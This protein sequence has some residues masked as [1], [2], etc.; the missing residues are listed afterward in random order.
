ME[1]I[2]KDEIEARKNEIAG[3]IK[4]G[5]VFIYGTD[6]IYGIGC[7]ATNSKAVNKIRKIK[8]RKDAPFSVI[9]PSK[10]WVL[11]NC[12]AK[13][14]GK[15][16]N[17]LPG[18]YTLILNLKNKNCVSKH[19]NP[20]NKTLGVRIPNHWISDF[21]SELGMPVVTTS[22]NKTDE[23]YLTSPDELQIGIKEKVDFMV[24]EG[25]I[26]GKPSIIIDLTKEKKQI[27]RR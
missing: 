8:Q 4:A 3:K 9:A 14:L 24:D 1:L 2:D 6:T 11:E 17:K 27:I 7:D 12:T 25:K 15:E 22:V 20:A 23:P 18:P 26:L 16:L 21:V 5:A 19:V 10:E 13:G